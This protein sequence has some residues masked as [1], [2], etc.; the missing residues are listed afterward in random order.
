MDGFGPEVIGLANEAYE[1]VRERATDASLSDRDAARGLVLAACAA[2]NR[3]GVDILALLSE[4]FVHL[5]R[6]DR[7]T[8]PGVSYTPSSP[9]PSSS[10]PND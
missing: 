10:P 2:A 8:E 3:A 7:D 4:A 9:S 5:E 6:L 1:T